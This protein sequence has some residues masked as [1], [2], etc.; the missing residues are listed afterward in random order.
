LVFVI[1]SGAIALDRSR[2]L[3]Y[4]YDMRGQTAA[5]A[6]ASASASSQ[7][8]TGDT[9]AGTAGTEASPQ[10][11]Q[12]GVCSMQSSTKKDAN[13]NPVMVGVS[14][15]LSVGSNKGLKISGSKANDKLKAGTCE[16]SGI[17]PI[18]GKE[19]TTTG[20]IDK[21][22][23]DIFTHGGLPGYKPPI[24]PQGNYLPIEFSQT[25]PVGEAPGGSNTQV[26]DWFAQTPSSSNS[27]TG[28]VD[29]GSAER[30]IG[31]YAN[32]PQSSSANPDG[33][34]SVQATLPTGEVDGTGGLP[35]APRATVNL[36]GT[37]ENPETPQ[38]GQP[39]SN[40][41]FV[42]YN[43]NPND[44]QAPDSPVRGQAQVSIPE[45]K[46]EAVDGLPTATEAWATEGLHTGKETAEL[47]VIDDWTQW[48]TTCKSEACERGR[49][50]DT[51]TNVSKE[52]GPNGPYYADQP[53]AAAPTSP[54]EEAVPLPRPRP[55][56][57]I[58]PG[59]DQPGVDVLCRQGG[60]IG[61]DGK[62]VPQSE[63]IIPGTD[64]PGV[65]CSKGGCVGPDGKPI[66]ATEKPSP[67][68][69]L[70]PTD[71][72]GPHTPNGPNGPD[73]PGGPGGPGGGPTGDSTG[74]A[75]GGGNPLGALGSLLGALGKMLNQPQQPQKQPAQA[76]S[77]DPNIYAQQ[78][79]QYQ[80]QLDQYNY[81]MQQ[82]NYQVQQNQYNSYYYGTNYPAPPM[83][84]QPSPCTPSND[85]QCA[86]QPPQPDAASCSVGTWRAAYS[87]SCITNWQCVP[88]QN[89]TT[90]AE[91]SCAPDIVD[92]GSTLAISYSCAAGTA[93]GSGFSVTSQ[94]SGTASTTI[95]NPPDGANTATYTLTCTNQGQTSS[96]RCSVEINRSSIILVANP[97]S[98]KRGEQSLIGWITSGMQSCIVSSPDQGDFT[99]RN[100]PNTSANGTALTSPVTGD[101]G[102]VLTCQTFA[103]SIRQATTT[104]TTS[105]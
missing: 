75:S 11:A 91:I 87:G 83:P 76:C 105:N 43:E 80:Q 69:P 71:P 70:P 58:I 100:A 92:V 42:T 5:G 49:L 78:Q 35:Q 29:S 21:N 36:P 67:T 2:A 39:P 50:G 37:N 4:A 8:S 82:Y 12:K 55:E 25:P 94:P 44:S 102:F 51:T 95:A 26:G 45:V 23:K 20:D 16:S 54:S 15:K 31:A 99:T 101:A 89:A 19:F 62:P 27:N 98:V 9:A 3:Q 104:V 77:T 41:T 66:P 85:R 6:E 81:Q 1:V 53:G 28:F 93:S 68:V 33:S 47:P 60:C 56:N 57:G 79:Q 48:G 13:G 18:T 38:T 65:D 103:G 46:V 40:T 88:N 30:G 84:T 17:D 22:I 90:S 64:Q 32:A 86:S 10:G 73:G 74:N 7:T 14:N 24:D 72:R 34:A 97:K 59:A 96:A 61:P 52:V 63:G